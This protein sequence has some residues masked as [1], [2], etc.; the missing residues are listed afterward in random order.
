MRD[1]LKNYEFLLNEVENKEEYEERIYTYLKGLEKGDSFRIQEGMYYARIM[2]DYD[3]GEQMFEMSI[4][5]ER[6][7]VIKTIKNEALADE[8]AFYCKLIE[9]Q[10]EELSEESES[11][12][13]EFFF[14][15]IL[16]LFGIKQ[17]ESTTLIKILE[18]LLMYVEE[19]K[20][21]YRNVY[22]EKYVSVQCY[23]GSLMKM[24]GRFHDALVHFK[25]VEEEIGELSDKGSAK[26]YADYLCVCYQ[27]QGM[28][29]AVLKCLDEATHCSMK[30]REYA[31]KMF[32]VER[33]DDNLSDLADCYLYHSNILSQFLQEKEA[34]FF[35][36]ESLK[37]YE[38][39]QK[40]G[41]DVW[42]ELVST[43]A[44]MGRNLLCLK[45]YE[46]ALGC[47]EKKNN[48]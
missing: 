3:L 12:V 40:R 42:L 33:N 26:Q 44:S 43:Y 35:C 5:S 28:I 21:K 27:M 9:K 19:G 24:Q 14:Q 8:G 31:K 45:R 38:E 7:D 36:E 41:R 46:E 20:E 32:E 17:K 23:I 10:K 30:A 48:A 47:Q 16:V 34:L 37:I 6:E 18:V 2:N 4:Q 25:K 11:V 29:Y 39:L 1:T 22:M 15:H 13:C